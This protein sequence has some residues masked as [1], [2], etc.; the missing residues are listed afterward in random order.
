MPATIGCAQLWELARST[1]NGIQR[2]LS[3]AVSL[4]LN[5]AY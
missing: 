4:K 3:C 1:L 2:H 5:I